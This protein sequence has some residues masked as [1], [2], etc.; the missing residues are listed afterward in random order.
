MLLVLEVGVGWRKTLSIF[1]ALNVSPSLHGIPVCVEAGQLFFCLL[2]LVLSTVFASY[3]ALLHILTTFNRQ[4]NLK[5]FYFSQ[6]VS[7]MKGLGGES[8]SSQRYHRNVCS[9]L[10]NCR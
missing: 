10:Y 5:Q 9:M 7:E 6:W 2:G 8:P 4:F 1:P 3:R